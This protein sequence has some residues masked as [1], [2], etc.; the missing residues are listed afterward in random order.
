[1]PPIRPPALT[2]IGTSVPPVRRPSPR[3]FVPG[4]G[5]ALP[6]ALPVATPE[7]QDPGPQQVAADPLWVSRWQPSATVPL[8]RAPWIVGIRFWAQN[9]VYQSI[10]TPLP[11]YRI[12]FRWRDHAHAYTNI[13]REVWDHFR[14]LTTSVGQAY[15]R[16]ILGPGW[17]PGAG[18]LYPDFPL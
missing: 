4:T 9:V 15:H 18:A 8:S 5:T 6:V 12:D 2:N 10:G 1:M 17:R 14:T 11:Y 13:P 7:G 3:V 16:L